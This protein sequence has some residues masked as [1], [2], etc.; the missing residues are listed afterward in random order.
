[1]CVGTKWNTLAR[2]VVRGVSMI[3]SVKWIWSRSFS[4]DRS[5]HVVEVET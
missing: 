5:A 2:E 4:S 3:W 1:M